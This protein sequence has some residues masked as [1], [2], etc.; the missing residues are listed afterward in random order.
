MR[1]TEVT[2]GRRI[3]VVLE[4]GD[5]VMSAIAEACA[6]HTI[7]RAVIPVFLGAFTSVTL[8]GTREPVADMDAP[9]PQKT[10]VE[11]VEGIGSGTVAPLADG[12]LVVHL[13]AAVGDKADAALAY[14]GHVLA[15]A[16]HYTAEVV[17]DEVLGVGLVRRPDAASHGLSTICFD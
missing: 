1:S 7:T 8:I 17:I 12:T 9:M 3:V 4:P 14:A 13:H 6:A 2:H 11:W 16:T 15:A 10:V 5:D